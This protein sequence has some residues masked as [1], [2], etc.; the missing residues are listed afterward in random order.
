MLRGYVSVYERRNPVTSLLEDLNE[1]V[2]QV[3][4]QVVI[5]RQVRGGRGEEIGKEAAVLTSY[6]T[7]DTV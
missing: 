7:H 3:V 1:V 6:I 5:G 4:Q 2:Q